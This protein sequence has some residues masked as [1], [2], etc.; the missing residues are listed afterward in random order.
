MVIFLEF[1]EILMILL[2]YALI[3]DDFNCWFDMQIF[4]GVNTKMLMFEL[5]NEG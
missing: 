3:Y 4:Y 2:V 1:L 5:L